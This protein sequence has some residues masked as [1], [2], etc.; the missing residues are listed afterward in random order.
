MML[1]SRKQIDKAGQVMLSSKDNVE[2]EQ[3]VAIIDDWRQNHLPVLKMLGETLSDLFV[4]NDVVYL[5]TSQRLKRM[6]S[7]QD[8]LDKK[9]DMKLGG[10]NDIGGL[11]YVFS[12]T[13]SVY[14]AIKAILE[15][16]IVGFE[17]LPQLIA[18]PEQYD[19]IKS[20]AKSGYRSVHLVFKCIN[21]DERYE[22]LRVELQ[23]RTKL[24]HNWATAVESGEV[25]T[26]QAL[27]NSE[28]PIEWLEFFKIASALFSLEEKCPLPEEYTTCDIETLKSSLMDLEEKAKCFTMLKAF[29]SALQL[30]ENS[31]YD[32]EYY[33]LY[34]DYEKRIV[35]VA[36]YA[37]EQQAEASLRYNELEKKIETP[38]NAV[39]LVSAASLK[40]LREA[41]PSYFIDTSEFLEQ[42]E[43][44]LNTINS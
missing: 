31:N 27:K 11:R 4:K 13:D 6:T 12:D 33:L 25:I 28:G 5:F 39:I 30:I 22:G 9:P 35:N 23:L 38:N 34:V 21:A 16:K 44:C 29:K 1:Y 37:I 7:I 36:P 41:Y 3:A 19:Y 2:V 24:Q 40:D 15:N 43:S 14:K 42:I 26:H 8:K 10:L 32:T 20:P 17:L 18:N